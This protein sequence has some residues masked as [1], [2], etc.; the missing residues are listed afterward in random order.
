MPDKVVKCAENTFDFP[1]ECNALW[2]YTMASTAYRYVILLVSLVAITLLLA[3]T[4]LFNF[5]VICMKPEE[6]RVTFINDTRYYSPM[7]EGW[8]MSATYVGSIVATLPAVYLGMG[9][10]SMYMVIGVVPSEYGGVKERA[11]FVAVLSSVCQFGPFSTMPISAVFCQSSVRWPGAYY[12]FGVSTIVSLLV[13]F[14]MY[15]EGSATSRA[16]S[17][18]KVLSAEDQDQDACDEFVPYKRIFTTLSTYGIISSAFGDSLAYK[19]FILYG[20]I[21]MN[22]VILFLGSLSLNFR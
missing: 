8:V 9:M 6:R 16:P 18:A 13:F 21:Y 2:N 14:V 17:T 1:I 7:E 15:K 22:K 3:N 4:V 12:F 19:V 11:F 5:T 20:P 10:S